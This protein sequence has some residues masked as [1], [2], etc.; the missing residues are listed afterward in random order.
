M[1]EKHHSARKPQ[2]VAVPRRGDIYLVSFDPTL[3]AEIKKTRPALII[4]NDI[5][6]QYSPMTIVAA[7]TSKIDVP[8]YPTEVIME[9]RDSGLPEISAVV[10]N[11]IRSVDKQRLVKRIGKAPTGVMERVNRAISIS[12]GLVEI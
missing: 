3:G 10:L 4:Q 12:L 7:I 8:P 6:N 11:Q 1:A 5:G 2:K 9:P